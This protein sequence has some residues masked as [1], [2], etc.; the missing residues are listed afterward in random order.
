MTLAG[1]TE[2]RTYGALRNATRTL[3]APLQYA[4]DRGLQHCH[5]RCRNSPLLASD[6]GLGRWAPPDPRRFSGSVDQCDQELVIT[7]SLDAVTKPS[8]TV[9]L[10]RGVTHTLVSQGRQE[11]RMH[12]TPAGPSF[13][14]SNFF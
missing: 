3:D 10:S 2:L 8:T 5:H 11:I 7:G 12:R 6:Q 1:S 14:F 9:L 4:K 13:T